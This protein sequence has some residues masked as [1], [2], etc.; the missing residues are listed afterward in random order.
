MIER[1]IY[2]NHQNKIYFSAKYFRV[3]IDTLQRFDIY[4]VY[5]IFKLIN[6]DYNMLLKLRQEIYKEFLSNLLIH[7]NHSYLNSINYS[8]NRNSN[9]YKYHDSYKYKYDYFD[10]YVS[11]MTDVFSFPFWRDSNYNLNN[12]SYVIVN[13][14]DY[15]GFELRHTYNGALLDNS[16]GFR[17]DDRN[18]LLYDVIFHKINTTNFEPFDSKKEEFNNSNHFFAQIV[19]DIFLPYQI[20][21]ENYSS[22]IL[23][24]DCIREHNIHDL[25]M[26]F[27]DETFGEYSLLSD[28][29]TFKE[30]L[31]DSTIIF[32]ND[33]PNITIDYNGNTD[34]LITELRYYSM[35]NKLKE[36]LLI[37]RIERVNKAF[38]M[39]NQIDATPIIYDE[40]GNVIGG[41]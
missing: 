22:E 11:P 39:Y 10:F 17:F 37:Y 32:F 24:I 5:H 27:R 36:Y 14:D 2:I 30:L 6:D 31:I 21:C 38:T 12:D 19:L 3:I 41:M 9:E 33:Y 28:F 4:T 35:N 18:A 23:M 34:D 1:V 16:N 29:V 15:G 7:N 13:E 40:F 20:T 26:V 25:F 8:A